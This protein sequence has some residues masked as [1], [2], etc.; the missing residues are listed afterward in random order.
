M[1]VYVWDFTLILCGIDM[2]YFGYENYL[3]CCFLQKPETPKDPDDIDTDDG[4]TKEQVKE[5][6]TE[7]IEVEEIYVKYKN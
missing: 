4:E 7:I 2:Y 3:K 1:L 5:E 6:R